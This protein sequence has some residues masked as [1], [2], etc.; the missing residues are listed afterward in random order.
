MTTPAMPEKE[1]KMLLEKWYSVPR[2][3]F[4]TWL[5][6]AALAEADVIEAEQVARGWFEIAETAASPISY[7]ETLD[8]ADRA[9]QRAGEIAASMG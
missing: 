6:N 2:E 3:V 8:V 9:Q 1:D 7:R 4:L 5:K